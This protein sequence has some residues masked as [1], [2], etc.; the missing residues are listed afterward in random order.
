MFDKISLLHATLG[1]ICLSCDDSKP[2]Q[3]L[4][5]QPAGCEGTSSALLPMSKIN[6]EQSRRTTGNGPDQKDV[7]PSFQLLDRFNKHAKPTA[8]SYVVLSSLHEKTRPDLVRF[9]FRT[10]AGYKSTV[11][12]Y[13]N[14]NISLPNTQQQVGS[15][16]LT[17][18]LHHAA[19]GYFP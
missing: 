9:I 18:L 8:I 7:P 16:F 4:Q 15:P 19:L 14:T 13:R 1:R 5:S 3:Q 17:F 12:G 6:I 11:K 10:S 2:H